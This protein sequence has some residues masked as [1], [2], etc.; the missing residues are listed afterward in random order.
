[1]A[2]IK[3]SGKI[4]ISQILF[5]QLVSYELVSSSGEATPELLTYLHECLARDLGAV[6]ESHL[7]AISVQTAT[8]PE[9]KSNDE[10]EKPSRAD[11]LKKK[12]QN[13]GP[14]SNPDSIREGFSELHKLYS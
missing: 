6:H 9:P 12:L 10:D 7:A 5:R 8:Q 4:N 11:E 2:D 13:S 3:I 14:L 1:M